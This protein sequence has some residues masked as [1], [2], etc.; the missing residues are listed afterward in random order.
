[1]IV[2]PRYYRFRAFNNTGVTISAGNLKVYGRR[3]KFD[4]TGQL[5]YESPESTV[6]TTSGTITTGSYD[7][8][9]VQDNNSTGWLGGAFVLEVTM[10]GSP[11]GNV[12][13]FF[14]RSTDGTTRIDSQGVSD[15]V[16]VLNFTSAT[17]KYKSFSL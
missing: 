15:V 16:A 11:S 13:L 3:F 4:T 6:W 12:V 2:L 8:S 7:Q 17:T 14:E 10:T 5:S 9:A 1:M